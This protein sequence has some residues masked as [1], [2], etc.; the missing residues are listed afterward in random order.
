V[1]F[2]DVQGWATIAAVPLAAIAIAKPSLGSRQRELRQKL[3][4]M[5]YKVRNELTQ[6]EFQLVQLQAG[7]LPAGA[8]NLTQEAVEY[9][10]NAL[11]EELPE[12]EDGIRRPGPRHRA[13]LRASIAG[14][15]YDWRMFTGN[16]LIAQRLGQGVSV[17]WDAFLTKDL[18]PAI[19]LITKNLNTLNSLDKWS[20]RGRF[21]YWL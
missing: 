11:R 15:V 17:P 12:I 3:R 7:V 10:N 20:V 4:A 14:A 16:I 6:I 21:L 5:L 19:E 9:T 1:N 13:Q 2:A 8:A 18:Q